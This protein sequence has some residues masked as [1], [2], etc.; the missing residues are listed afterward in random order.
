M[1]LIGSAIETE[2]RTTTHQPRTI[3]SQSMVVSIA[4]GSAAGF[5]VKLPHSSNGA[6]P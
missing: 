4:E 1:T 2:L 3:A 6:T 5:G